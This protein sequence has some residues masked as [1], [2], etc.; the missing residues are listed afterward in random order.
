MQDD[1][2]PLLGIGGF[3]KVDGRARG[4]PQPG[5]IGQMQLAGLA[6]AGVVV[7]LPVPALRGQLAPHRGHVTGGE[8]AGR[9]AHGHRREGAQ[10]APAL[11]AMVGR[12]IERMAGRTFG[13]RLQA[14]RG[15]EL[16]ADR[17]H[18]LPGP[19]MVGVRR[20]PVE[21]ALAGLRIGGLVLQHGKPFGRLPKRAVRQG[22]QACRRRR[23]R[24]RAGGRSAVH[25]RAWVNSAWNSR[26]CSMACAMYFFTMRSETPSS[27]PISR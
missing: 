7:A 18:G 13:G 24:D 8:Q 12:L 23:R 21:P 3:G 19:L 14:A 9:A 16:A 1:A 10:R 15:I 26:H 20:Q 5:A 4:Q 25:A 27:A 17:L 2:R 6:D 22:R 11:T